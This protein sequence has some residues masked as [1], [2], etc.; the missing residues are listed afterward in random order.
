MSNLLSPMNFGEK[1]YNKFPHKYREDDVLQDYSLKRYIEALADG[2]YSPIIEDL[3]GIT[4]LIDADKV[5]S[6]VLHLLFEQYGFKTFN[7]IPE[8]Y[9]RYLLPKLGEAYSLKGSLSVV[10]FITSSLSGVRVELELTTDDYSN[11]HL[12]IR[13][14][15]DYNIGDYFPNVEHFTRIL[16]NFLPF[17][18]G[19]T[20]IYV[21]MF[22]ESQ[23]LQVKDNDT[24]KITDQKEDLGV[25]PSGN[26]GLTPTTNTVDKLLNNSFIL[27]ERKYVDTDLFK[28]TI[29]HLL[30]EEVSVE[31]IDECCLE[32]FK[33][34]TNEDPILRVDDNLTTLATQ[35]YN[36]ASSIS[37]KS[38]TQSC[39]LGE[40]IMGETVLGEYEDSSE[41]IEDHIVTTIEDI[42]GFASGNSFMNNTNNT[43]NTNFR[44]NDIGDI[45]CD[46]ITYS[47]GD[48]IYI[49]N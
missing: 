29:T 39:V 24:L 41:Y 43:L 13:F 16:E 18:L 40:A 9:L 22:Y 38:K 10:E 32:V 45:C 30:A 48:E 49:L 33:F 44:L 20:L 12:D 5:S 14:E 26:I 25:I 27:N 42:V 4:S 21:Y 31:S 6:E 2:G 15:M 19:R 1:L 47:N 28:D 3:N 37:F 46:K 23:S 7:G 11:M 36:E 17:Y 34:T 8:P 35:V